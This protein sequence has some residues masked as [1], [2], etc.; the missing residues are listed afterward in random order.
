MPRT[1]LDQAEEHQALEGFTKRAATD[2]QHR[3]QFRFGGEAAAD[4]K[5]SAAN[6]PLNA[7][8]DRLHD[9]FAPYG[10]ARHRMGGGHFRF[11]FYTQKFV[12]QT[13]FLSR[14]KTWHPKNCLPSNFS[15]I[16]SIQFVFT[17]KMRDPPRRAKLVFF[18]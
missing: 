2:T 5:F 13:W 6:Q 16:G 11:Q 18:N 4:A 14:T 12:R 8:R 15:T 10:F 7:A 1:G 9:S 3:G 17:M